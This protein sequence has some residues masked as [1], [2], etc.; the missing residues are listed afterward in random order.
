MI[1]SQLEVVCKF[2]AA[3]EAQQAGTFLNCYMPP[4]AVT[5]RSRW[6]EPIRDLPFRA[7][8]AKEDAVNRATFRRIS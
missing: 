5:S 2:T 4:Y 7:V 8:E 6:I 1:F 3:A